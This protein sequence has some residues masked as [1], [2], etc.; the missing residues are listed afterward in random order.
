M[1]A[2]AASLRPRLCAR[3]ERLLADVDERVGAFYASCPPG[4][5]HRLADA[6]GDASFDQDPFAPYAGSATAVRLVADRVSLP[7]NVGCVDLLDVLDDQE[8]AV[9]ASADTAPLLPEQEQIANAD[10]VRAHVFASPQEYRALLRRLL[11]L[12][13]ITAR[14][15]RPRCVNGAFGVP[16]SDDT[17]R[18]IVDAR[19]ANALFARPLDPQLPT[20]ADVATLTIPPGERVLA[21]KSDLSNCYHTIRVPDWLSEYFGLPA[22]RAGDIGLEGVDPETLVWPRLTRLA[23]GFSHS[24]RLAQRASLR[25]LIDSGVRFRDLLLPGNKDTSLDRPR[26]LLYL[27]DLVIMGLERH[28]ELI[29]AAMRDYVGLGQRRGWVFALAKLK[30]ARFVLDVLGLVLDGVRGSYAPDPTKLLA[31]AAKARVLVAHDVVSLRDLS[32]VIGKLTWA[33]LCF[34]PALAA[35]TAVYRATRAARLAGSAVV[36]VGPA[37]RY[38]INLILGLLPLLAADLRAEWH[39]DVVASDASNVGL[40]IVAATPGLAS[41]REAALIHGRT[42]LPPFVDRN[43]LHPALD[44]VLAARWRC[45][46]SSPVRKLQHINVLETV[47]ATAALRWCLSTPR[48]LGKRIL[49]LNDSSVVTAALSK[50]RSSSNIAAAVRRFAAFSLAS[51]CRVSVV[52]VPSERQPADQASRLFGRL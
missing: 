10:S 18:L 3:D 2:A 15:A 50:G 31:V 7:D 30:T 42:S 52:W 9:W 49:L 36:R 46:V 4:L 1:P 32:S 51:G 21:A 27:D 25:L 41:I 16:K 35:F 11:R 29:D 23:M 6:A 13:M 26:F 17:I 33:A 48:S 34:R 45:I 28:K 38:E 43:D 20:P 44:Q 5:W 14:A 37:V 22:V 8:A 47:A 24:V 12:R 40:G 19:P 39:A